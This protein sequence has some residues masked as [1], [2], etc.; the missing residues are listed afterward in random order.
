MVDCGSR[1]ADAV[2]ARAPGPPRPCLPPG[3][4]A[5]SPFWRRLRL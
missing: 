2:A 1:R 3:G 5:G 4:G